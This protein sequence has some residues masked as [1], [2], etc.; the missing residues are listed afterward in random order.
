M[1]DSRANG[2]GT[3]ARDAAR[4]VRRRPGTGGGHTGSVRASTVALLGGSTGV[5]TPASC[6]ASSTGLT[7]LTTV[8]VPVPTTVPITTSVPSGVG[9]SP[10]SRSETNRGPHDVAPP[11]LRPGPCLAGVAEVT[12]SDAD[13]PTDAFETW[14]SHTD[15]HRTDS[16]GDGVPDGAGDPDGDGRVDGW[17]Q[18]D[19]PV[20]SVLRPSLGRAFDDVPVSYRDG[21]HSGTLEVAMHPCAFGGRS[22]SSTIV[23]YGDSRAAQ[24]LPALL[25]NAAAHG[26][27]IVE[28]TKSAC[29]AADVRF[30]PR[31]VPWRRSH[32]S[33]L[34]PSHAALAVLPSTRRHPDVQRRYVSAGRP[35]GA[36]S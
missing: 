21:C 7:G 15:P 18:D 8:H 1:L 28:L 31:T 14:S 27:R 5:S 11:A 32:V 36:A 12:D 35:A 3:R 19:R 34:A 6:P 13:G 2:D 26:W 4:G 30:Q 10:S 29:P 17:D 33:R 9:T 20:P 22:G 16:D 23:L 24:W 25:P